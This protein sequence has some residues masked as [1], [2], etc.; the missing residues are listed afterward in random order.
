MPCSFRF[1]LSLLLL[2][3]CV[4]SPVAQEEAASSVSGEQ[5]GGS[6]SE[7]RDKHR[8]WLIV[9]RGALLDARGADASVLSEVY[10]EGSTRQNYPRT[11][12]TIA[13]KLNKYM[14][15]HASITAAQTLSDS[16]FIIFFNVL[17]IRRPLG[18]PYAYGELFIILNAPSKP[19]IIWKTRGSGMFVDDAIGD[20]ISELKAMRGE[21]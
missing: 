9:R 18:T 14:R 5:P 4:A 3:G 10:K 15:E 19:R 7:L 13:R 20:F 2:I 11:F 6:L 12:N 17:E 21:R 8:V 16:E 1:V